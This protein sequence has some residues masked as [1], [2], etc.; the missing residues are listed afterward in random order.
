MISSWLGNRP[1]SCFEK[2]SA[3]STTTSKTP[4]EP[5]INTGSIA[6]ACF[7]AAAR[8]VARGR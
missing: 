7:S 4:S 8:P 2:I 1:A 5:R 6:N 3:P